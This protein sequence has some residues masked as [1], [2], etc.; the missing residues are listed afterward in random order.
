M[1]TLNPKA[2]G[3]RPAGPPLESTPVVPA[4][5]AET[6]GS[7]PVV[8]PTRG[9]AR[10]VV[11]PSSRFPTYVGIGLVAIGFAL[12][13]IAWAQIASL[14]NVALQMPYLVSAGFTGLGLV[15]VGLVLINIAA[16]RQDAAERT[17]QMERLTDVLSDL[18]HALQDLPE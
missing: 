4:P 15:M 16:K 5:V 1:A 18:Q 17:R 14:L 2:R 6:N 8:R 7:R 11:D 12:I 13:G 3:R 9:L 10:L